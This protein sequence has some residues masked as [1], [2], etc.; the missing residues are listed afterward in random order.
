[1]EVCVGGPF[2]PGIEMT[3][4]SAKKETYKSPFR[5]ADKFNAGD[6]TCYMAMPWQADFYECNT[7]WWPAQRPDD[8]V[9]QSEYISVEQDYNVNALI[10]SFTKNEPEADALANH[11][12]WARGLRSNSDQ[13][14][15]REG[16]I[17]MVHYWHE[18][19]F[20]NP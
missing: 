11:V 14:K 4:I 1:M 13:I 20:C 18:L 16:D 9:P 2:Y 8:V 6:I 3:Y 15:V 10:I 5:L 12:P 19:G 17:D 7:H